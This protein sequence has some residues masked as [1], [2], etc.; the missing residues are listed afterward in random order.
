MKKEC[1]SCAMMI[2]KKAGT[3]PICQYEFPV[4]AQSKIPLI[5]LVLVI[6]FL[7]SLLF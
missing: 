2:D 6:I 1:P 5:A 3:C 7:I 4:K